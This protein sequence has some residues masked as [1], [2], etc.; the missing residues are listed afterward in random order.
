[1]TSPTC[2][3]NPSWLSDHDLGNADSMEFILGH[4]SVC[5]AV[6]VNVFCVATGIAGYES[7]SETDAE[8]MRSVPE[9]PEM[10][11]FVRSWSREHV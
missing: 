7:V 1:M 6:S 5:G 8:R 2:C 11:S 3:K 9:G 4:C 10:K